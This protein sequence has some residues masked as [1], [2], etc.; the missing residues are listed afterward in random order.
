M[1]DD[2]YLLLREMTF[3][4]IE[5]DTKAGNEVGFENINPY[6]DRAITSSGITCDEETRKRLFTDVEYQF[7]ITHA[8]GDVIFDDYDS[9]QEWY[10]NEGVNKPYF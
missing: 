4:L 6:I 5:F 3:I 7:K 1:T 9:R 8:K 2:L 10:S